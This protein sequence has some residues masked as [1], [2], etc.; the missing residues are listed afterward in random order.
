[1]T[2]FYFTG[3]GNSLAAAKRIGGE[4]NSIPQV[5]DGNDL[6]YKDDVIGI[7]FPI[8]CKRKCKSRARAL[9]I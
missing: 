2:V 3:T 5:V 1:M 6:H 9:I 4:F 7:V 8:T